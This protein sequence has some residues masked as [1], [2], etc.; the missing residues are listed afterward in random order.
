M[1][2]DRVGPGP[3]LGMG[4]L[5]RDQILDADAPDAFYPS[6]TLVACNDLTDCVSRQNHR[7]L[8]TKIRT[9]VGR[10][11]RRVTVR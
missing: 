7:R 6:S 4:W 1:V 10:L 2:R 5:V 3:W 11:L 9:I 8:P